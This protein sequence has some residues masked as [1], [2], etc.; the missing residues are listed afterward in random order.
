LSI[1]PIMHIKT[2]RRSP[3]RLR[4]F[5]YLLEEISDTVWQCS[6]FTVSKGERTNL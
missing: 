6:L 3:L 2:P 4:F 1:S 5:A